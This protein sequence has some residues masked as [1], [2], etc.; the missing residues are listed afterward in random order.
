MGIWSFP[1][2]HLHAGDL[3]Q[4]DRKNHR[5][6]S[7]RQYLLIHSIIDPVK[8]LEDFQQYL[9]TLTIIFRA[10]KLVNT[11]LPRCFKYVFDLLY[12]LFVCVGLRAFPG[13]K[14]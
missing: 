1:T 13:G 12:N 9:R 4:K 3:V 2:A 5:V 11:G 7:P 14:M 8:I 6:I 10:F